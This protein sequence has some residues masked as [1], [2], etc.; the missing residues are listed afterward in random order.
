MEQNP[1]TPKKESKRAGYRIEALNKENTIFN[2]VLRRWIISLDDT[3]KGLIESSFFVFLL[4]LLRQFCCC[5]GKEF[6]SLSQN[7]F[8]LWKFFLKK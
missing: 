6:L 4:V 7:C 1:K 8:S 3:I 2:E 5:F